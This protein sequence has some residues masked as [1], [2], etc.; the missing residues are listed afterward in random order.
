MYYYKFFE[1]AYEETVYKNA[2]SISEYLWKIS[3]KLKKIQIQ[4]GGA[5]FS[6]KINKKWLSHEYN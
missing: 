3:H 1:V 4:M 2:I 5:S 6:K